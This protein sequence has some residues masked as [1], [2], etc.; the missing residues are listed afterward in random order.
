MIRPSSV[1][2]VLGIVFLLLGPRSALATNW[3]V[4]ICIE[5]DVDFTDAPYGDYYSDNTDDVPATGV[6]LQVVNN[7]TE[8]DWFFDYTSNGT[9]TGCMPLYQGMSD[10]D[11][12]SIRVYMQNRVDQ[13]ND[14]VVYDRWTS[15]RTIHVY[16]VAGAF[17]PD[18]P[19]SFTFV[20]RP[21]DFGGDAKG[22]VNTAASASY[23]VDRRNGDVTSKVFR[24]Y[25]T[26]SE[27]CPSTVGCTIPGDGSWIYPI[28]NKKFEV[29]HETGHN[30]AHYGNKSA[31]PVCSYG[32]NH[33]EGS[34]CPGDADPSD[35]NYD[36]GGWQLKSKEWRTAAALEGFVHFYPVAVWNRQD[37]SDCELPYS[38]FSNDCEGPHQHM[39]MTCGGEFSSRGA[40]MDW[41]TFWWD[42]HQDLG[43]LYGTVLDIWD[44]TNPHSWVSSN[45]S[46]RL[47]D[48]AVSNGIS[49]SAWDGKVNYN[50]TDPD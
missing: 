25:M 24:Y 41:V 50:G 13:D 15:P 29:V 11:S 34:P 19:G 43:V 45:V 30:I 42:V 47:R 28:R 49:G 6:R 2:V 40:A 4:R 12:Y 8:G 21:G 16:E 3:N 22:Y 46:S 36:G 26:T 44:D 39:E 10:T 5:Y 1:L 48:A 33:E 37:Q 32:L 35:P 7:D 20:L 27:F 14:I 17:V 31:V 9:D 23:A 38:Y 18:A